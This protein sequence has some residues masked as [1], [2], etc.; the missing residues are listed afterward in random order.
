[1][2]K[3]KIKITIECTCNK[4]KD[5]ATPC[6]DEFKEMLNDCKVH[7]DYRPMIREFG[8]KS[9]SSSRLFL[10]RYCPWCGSKLPACLLDEWDNVLINEYGIKNPDSLKE[11]DAP[12]EMQTDEWWKK[13][14]L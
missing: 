9:I 1:M 13:R 5:L 7:L 14:G 3:S 2:K 4:F 8:I 10:I 11:E 6:C 12:T